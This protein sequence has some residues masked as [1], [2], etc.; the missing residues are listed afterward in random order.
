MCCFLPLS[1]ALL[2]N[3]I[4]KHPAAS[5]LSLSDIHFGLSPVWTEDADTPV[6]VAPCPQTNLQVRGQRSED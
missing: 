3:E 2:T 6:P 5:P 1:P 4:M